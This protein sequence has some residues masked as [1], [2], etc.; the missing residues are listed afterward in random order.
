MSGAKHL[1]IQAIPLDINFSRRHDADCPPRYPVRGPAAMSFTKGTKV[2]FILDSVRGCEVL[3]I[4]RSCSPRAEVAAQRS[5]LP[6]QRT[7]VG[8]WIQ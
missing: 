7:S 1:W 2:R 8:R 5:A 4:E 6:L 3:I